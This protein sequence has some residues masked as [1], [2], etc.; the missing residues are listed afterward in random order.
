MLMTPPP[1]CGGA[2]PAPSP[3]FS[4]FSRPGQQ[5]S[6]LNYQQPQPFTHPGAQIQTLRGVASPLQGNPLTQQTATPTVNPGQGW[7]HQ[8]GMPSPTGS[9]DM[10]ASALMNRG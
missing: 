2:S 9:V 7:M 6:G 5:V 4:G 8:G 1:A 3:G 10:M